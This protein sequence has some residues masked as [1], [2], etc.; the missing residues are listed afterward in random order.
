MIG[1]RSLYRCGNVG[2]ARRR[3]NP[4]RERSGNLRTRRRHWRNIGPLESSSV[5]MC[6]G[7][8][9]GQGG[10]RIQ[11]P[12]RD[13]GWK[14][15]GPLSEVVAVAR[16]K[17]RRNEAAG[18]GYIRPTVPLPIPGKPLLRC[19]EGVPIREPVTP[20]F[21]PCPGEVCPS[22]PIRKPIQREQS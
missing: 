15:P 21:V 14:C 17:R 19:V 10:R 16:R 20:H 3:G 13:P 18:S 11:L 6:G 12:A 2:L 7:R 1:D 5:L 8:R 22:E 9:N 4:D